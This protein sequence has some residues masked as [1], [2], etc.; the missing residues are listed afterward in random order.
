LRNLIVA[1]ALQKNVGITVSLLKTEQQAGDLDC[2]PWTV[3][4]LCRRAKKEPLQ[5]REAI[6][7]GQTLRKKHNLIYQA[8]IAANIIAGA[9]EGVSLVALFPN[10]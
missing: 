4:N 6:I 2:G 1:A 5:T 3:D 10:P 7:A 9:L 8:N